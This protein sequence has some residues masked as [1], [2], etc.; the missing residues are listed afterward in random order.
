[1]K[2]TALDIINDL[3]YRGALD[4]DDLD[5]LSRVA[6]GY[7]AVEKYLQQA[8]RLTVETDALMKPEIIRE[9]VIRETVAWSGGIVESEGP[10]VE[11]DVVLSGGRQI[12]AK[13]ISIWPHDVLVIPASILCEV[14][15]L[16]GFEGRVR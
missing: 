6:L 7:E 5:E 9:T 4:A 8:P 15:G 14:E 11:Q 1:V 13:V 2:R 10:P 3:E 16:H 12:K